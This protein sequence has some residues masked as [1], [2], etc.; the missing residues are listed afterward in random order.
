MI[1]FYMLVFAA[2]MPNHPL[3]EAPLAGLTVMKWLGIVC[4]INA[5]FSA[6]KRRRLPDFTNSLEARAFLVLIGIAGL[7]AVTLGGKGN[8]TFSPM[9]SYFS[10]LLLFFATIT[11]VNSFERLHKALL[12]AIAGSAFASVYVIREFQLSGGTNLRP[13]YVAG[14]SNYFAACCVLVMPIAVYFA[15][16][17][18]SPWE[19]RFC[20]VSLV[21]IFIAFTLASSRGGLVG[22]CVAILYMALRSGRSRRTAIVAT[23][24]LLPLF[25]FSPASPLSR[26][27]H[28]D[29]GD[30]LGAQIRLD[31]WREGLEMVKNH[32]ITGVGLGNFTAYSYAGTFGA[33]GMKGMACNTFLE[34]TAELGFTGL[35]AYCAILG[36]ALMS[37]GKVRAE[38]KK[39]K[40]TQL[41]YAGEGMQ[42]GLLGFIAASMFLSAE[43]QKPFWVFV[44][45]SATV[46][47][48]L[49]QR[50]RQ[51][52]G[53]RKQTAAY[54]VRN[55]VATKA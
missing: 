20:V 29:F 14:D 12:A 18:S 23:L 15:R 30:E 3:F 47:S 26:M 27:L 53:R 17:K 37:A 41:L 7:S 39:H 34:I 36:G 8:I 45:L 38:G 21:I 22:L 42:A 49:M 16:E 51:Q 19:R 11:L 48:L 1:F 32:P 35:L 52:N 10:F 6:I 43:Y 24:V 55:Y 46:S 33:K 9:S 2:P 28:P 40:Q 50:A 5:L 54:G 13:G 4:C 44:A 31:F 25:V